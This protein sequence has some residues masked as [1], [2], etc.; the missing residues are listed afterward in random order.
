MLKGRYLEEIKMYVTDTHIFLWHLMNDEKISNVAKSIF[1]NCD[2]ENETIIVP[3]I[4]LIE[5]IF[6]CEKRKIEIS[7]QEI[8]EKMKK[9]SNYYIYPLNGSV[10]FECSKIISSLYTHG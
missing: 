8:L 9:A 2:N 1:E 10:V 7:F 6:I 4:A 3:S 5:S